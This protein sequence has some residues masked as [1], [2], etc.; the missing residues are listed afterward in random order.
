MKLSVCD[1]FYNKDSNLSAVNPLPELIDY[2]DRLRYI[3]V[4]LKRYGLIFDFHTSPKFSRT[5]FLIT[6]IIYISK[7]HDRFIGT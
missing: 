1:S 3:Y 6:K 7:L 2:S 4:L 5:F